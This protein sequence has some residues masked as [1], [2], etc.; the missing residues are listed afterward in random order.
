MRSSDEIRIKY[1]SKQASI[2]NAWKKWI[3]QIDG[4]RQMDAVTVKQKTEKEYNERAQTNP[5]WKKEYGSLIF[6]MNKL[7]D[8]KVTSEFQYSMGVEYLFVG[9]EYF[10]L[11]RALKDFTLDYDTLSKSNGIEAAKEKLIASAEGFFKNW[12]AGVDKKIFELLTEEYYKQIAAPT[13][14]KMDAGYSKYADLIYSKSVFTDKDR[15]IQFVKNYK[16]KAAKALKKDVG[17]THWETLYTEFMENAVN[18]YREFDGKMNGL[19]QTYVKGKLEMFPDKK[20]WADA[21]S[22]LRITY[23][24]LEGSAPTDGMKYLEH[25]SIDGIIAKY[26]TGNPDF[27]ILP[28]MF[29]LYEKKDYGDYA[30]NGELW[31]CFTGSNHTTGGNSGSPVIDANGNLM[32]LNFDRSWESTMSDFMFDPDRCRNIVVDIRYVLWVIDK[33]AGAKHLVDE[34]T[35]VRE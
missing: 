22:T 2:A 27:E 30:Q 18:N 15:Y 8:E 12:D 6:D 1:S 23:G 33:Y 34:M 11:A 24:Q 5:L 16:P 29:E 14:S 32:G 17:Y 21:N 7:V 25:T 9:P 31:V 28:R 13:L 4:L 26:Y 3:G 19:L 20:H 10:K 35:L